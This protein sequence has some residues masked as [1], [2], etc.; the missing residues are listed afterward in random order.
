MIGKICGWLIF[1]F[2]IYFLFSRFGVYLI[3]NPVSS[4]SDRYVID[5]FDKFYFKDLENCFDGCL[6]PFYKPIK[7]SRPA[8]FKVIDKFYALD[9]NQVYYRD[10]KIVNADPLHF[11]LINKTGLAKDNKRLYFQEKPVAIDPKLDLNIENIAVFEIQDQ[12]NFYLLHDTIS[13]YSLVFQEDNFLQTFFYS[14]RTPFIKKLNIINP[15]TLKLDPNA[16]PDPHLKILSTLKSRCLGYDNQYFYI[17]TPYG[18]DISQAVNSSVPLKKYGGG[19]VQI[20][21]RV[22]FLLEEL[23]EA[24]PYSF[25]YYGSSDIELY[26]YYAK[27]K[28][29]VY[30]TTFPIHSADPATFEVIYTHGIDQTIW[31]Y[32]QN[33]KYIWGKIIDEKNKQLMNNFK[34]AADNTEIT[35]KKYIN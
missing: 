7:G 6:V 20:K 12:E 28:N 19:Y 4:V 24:D 2:L 30:F 10:K 1:L 18:V 26:T 5:L 8:S 17:V 16:C 3:S 14:Q 35:I 33:H 34:T 11:S 25:I 32:D 22:Y 9:N 27:D 21:N 31:A 29:S 23:P 13:F 15:K